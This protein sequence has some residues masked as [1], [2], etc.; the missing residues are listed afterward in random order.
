M[1]LRDLL[2]LYVLQPGISLAVEPTRV[3]ACTAIEAEARTFIAAA[4]AKTPVPPTVEQILAALH[5][6]GACID[7]AG[8]GDVWALPLIAAPT[9]SRGTVVDLI[10]DGG[11][12]P[13]I[14]VGVVDPAWVPIV[15][16]RDG[17]RI[18][19]GP[20]VGCAKAGAF[21]CVAPALYL[22][23]VGVSLNADGEEC[24][25]PPSD[26]SDAVAR[27]V[28]ASTLKY[29]SNSV[30]ALTTKSAES[31][32]ART[33]LFG[34]D[35]VRV[36][37]QPGQQVLEHV[38]RVADL[39]A[40]GRLDLLDDQSLAHTFDASDPSPTIPLVAM[41]LPD[42]SYSTTHP[43]IGSYYQAVCGALGRSPWILGAQS[44]EDVLKRVACAHVAGVPRTT[45]VAGLNA[46]LAAIDA[47]KEPCAAGI[48]CELERGF[49]DAAEW[50][51]DWLGSE[52]EPSVARRDGLSPTR[53]ATV[54]S[55]PSIAPFRTYRFDASQATD[56]D[57]GTAWQPK[58]W[59]EAWLELSFD[60]PTTVV[61]LEVANGFQRRDALGDLFAMN[62]RPS[63]VAIAAGDKRF[64][65][66]LDP[67][68]RAVQ[69][70][71]F[72]EPVTTRVLRITVLERVKGTRWDQV[73]LSEVII[74]GHATRA[75]S[76]PPLDDPKSQQ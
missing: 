62:S 9:V 45:L 74:L 1:R 22:S 37:T 6:I 53:V 33:V 30:L 54:S 18:P 20:A 60:S 23:G 69:R 40:D 56:G 15:V 39:N 19:W 58:A 26:G 57:L 12:E 43:E 72:P 11:E 63:R 17:Q 66:A 75:P 47:G 8:E 42:G 76:D 50:L 14:A 38:S 7:S 71:P 13:E 2:S 48:L 29:G 4:I 36:T 10:E 28:V 67:D 70:L 59:R 32:R 16:T 64:T 31:P 65:L 3:A 49:S 52:S 73:A 51:D 46:E 27:H 24:V 61:A 34:F 41:A 21:D 35:G 44:E 68:S 55:S 25:D 5:P